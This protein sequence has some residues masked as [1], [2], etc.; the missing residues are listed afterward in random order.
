M[1]N[2]NQTPFPAGRNTQKGQAMKPSLTLLTVAAGMVMAGT[3]FAAQRIPLSAAVAQCKTHV[4]LDQ[5][6]VM[7]GGAESTSSPRGEQLF[8]ACVY[9]KSGQY[10]S[11]E[12]KSGITISGSARI[13]VVVS[14]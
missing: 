1:Q 6:N 4:G 2:H 11:T 14:D 7:D 3:S 9:S 8:R 5:G 13:G 10:P 12:R